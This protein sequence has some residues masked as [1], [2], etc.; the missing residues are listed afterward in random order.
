MMDWWGV[1][2]VL[3]SWCWGCF[4][5]ISLCFSSLWLFYALRRKERRGPQTRPPLFQLLRGKLLLHVALVTGHAQVLGDGRN[6]GHGPAVLLKL[7]GFLLHVDLVSE[8]SKTPTATHPHTP[9]HTHT[10]KIFNNSRR[11]MYVFYCK[12]VMNPSRY[13]SSLVQFIT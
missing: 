11:I 1:H 5:I 3:V 9:A 13:G 8:V 10:N 6:E 4:W 12:A 2:P 7:C